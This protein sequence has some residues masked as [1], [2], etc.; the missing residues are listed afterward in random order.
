MFFSHFLQ[1]ESIKASL[2]PEYWFASI[3]D[4]AG[5]AATVTTADVACNAVFALCIPITLASFVF[6]R[7][8]R[9]IG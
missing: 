4:W 2:L 9:W 6:A 5:V 1:W 3:D 7:D 8:Y